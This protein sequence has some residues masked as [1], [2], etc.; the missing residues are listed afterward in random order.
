MGDIADRYYEQMVS[1]LSDEERAEAKSY[2]ELPIDEFVEAM[3]IWQTRYWP[4][5][6]ITSMIDFYESRKFLT[7]KQLAYAAII[8]A[9]AVVNSAPS[10]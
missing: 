8:M 2:L 5:D 4:D 10:N 6:T 9:E 3:K 7:K 1:E